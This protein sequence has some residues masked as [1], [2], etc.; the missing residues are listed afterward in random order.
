M[1]KMLSL[2]EAKEVAVS[3]LTHHGMPA[4]HAG[5]VADH[6]IYATLAGHDFAGLSRLQPIADMLKERGP[7]GTITIL[8]ETAISALIDGANVNGYVTSVLAMDKAIALA[9]RSGIGVVGVSNSW[10][11]GMLRYYVERA[12][13]AD[14]IGMHAGNSTA[15]VAPF[16]GIDRLLGTNPL[17]FAFPAIPTPLVIDFSSASVMWGDLLYH[18]QI[19]QALPEGRAVD[20][21]GLP[22][23][24]PAAALRGAILPWGGAR[25]SALSMIVQ[26]LGILGGSDPIVRDGGGRWG[27]FFLALDPELLMPLQ[28]FKKNIQSLQEQ[29]ES[30]RPVPDGAPVRVPGIAAARK[31]R[32]GKARGWLEVD[33][34]IYSAITSHCL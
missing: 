4:D 5:M 30:S 24:D 32:E 27:Y 23:C 29:V 21:T 34:P 12:A 14:L 18:Q 19:G 7:G 28:D 22:T 33:E 13:D 25:G 31:V 16:G 17:A 3:Y 26:A 10:F 2:A 1:K 9:K 6:L 8:R 15:R 11:S 20:T